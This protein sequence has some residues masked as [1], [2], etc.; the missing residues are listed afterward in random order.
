LVRVSSTE[1]KRRRKRAAPGLW[2]HARKG[3]DR[4]GA[5]YLLNY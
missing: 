5:A 3:G 2:L 4:I 1:R